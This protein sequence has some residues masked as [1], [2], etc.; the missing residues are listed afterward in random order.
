MIAEERATQLGADR[1]GLAGRSRA[2][3]GPVR[4]D[5]AERR[6]GR[7]SRTLQSADRAVR[8]NAAEKICSGYVV[9]GS[10]PGKAQA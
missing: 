2:Q 5:A 8:Q 10:D 4:Q 7:S 6:Q 9:D 1:G 3:T